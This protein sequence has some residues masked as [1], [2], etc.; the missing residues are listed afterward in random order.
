M[1]FTRFIMLLLMLWCIVSFHPTTVQAQSPDS[2]TVAST[3]EIRGRVL[4]ADSQDPVDRAE[5]SL[6]GT[7]LH[8]TTNR[9]GRFVLAGVTPGTHSLR[10]TRVGYEDILH[11]GITV[12]A[13]LSPEQEF[14]MRRRYSQLKAVTVT[15]GAY[16]FM[17]TNTATRQTM[18]REDIESVPQIGEDVFRAVNRLPGL[19]SGDYN[20]HFSIRGG[21]HD[22]T[23]ILLDGLELYEPYHLKDFNEGAISIVDAETIE[24]VQLMTGGFAAQYGNKRSG[25]FDITSRV[26]ETDKTR[27]SVGVSF[28]NARAMA[29]GPLWG[30]K[31]SWLVSA[32]SGF[33]DVVF[34]L[35]QQDDLPSPR[36]HDVF[37]K[38]QVR[39][40]PSH[41][42]S[43]DVLY[44]GDSW[45]FDARS[46]TGFADSLKT[47][48][49][50]NNRY[51]NSYVWSTLQSTLGS[52]TSVRSMVSASLV[53]RTRDGSE[54]YDPSRLPLYALSNERDY[55][56]L[57]FKQDWTHGVADAYILGFGVDVR[58]LKNTDR[59]NSIVFRDPD[60][61]TADPTGIY[62]VTTITNIDG[63]GTRL[64]LYLS[65][66]IRVRDPLIV[67]FGG[68]YDRASYTGDR[69]FS[70]RASAALRL[71]EGTTMRLGWGLYRQMQG[72]DEV[73]ALNND[74]RYFPSEKSEQWAG[75]LEQRFQSGA[76]LRVEAYTK[77]G[78]DLRPVYR[79]WKNGID[80]F[81][82]INEDRILVFP[83]EMTARGIELQYDHKLGERLRARAG[84]SFSI[85]EEVVDSLVSVNTA[86][87]VAFDTKHP[88]P[89]DQRHAVNVD[90]TYRLRQRWSLNGSL[91]FHTGWPATH[92]S[93]VDVV[94]EDGEPDTSVRPNKIYG[95]RL[96]SY[97]RFDVRATRRW[98]TK[99]GDMRF[100]A[101]IVN[102]T[103]HGNV[104]GYDYFRTYDTATPPNIVLEKDEETWFTILPSLGI[105]WSSSF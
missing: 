6:L 16:S 68:R 102:L 38:M 14:S 56:I 32:R 96:P 69:D 12:A 91:A 39:L 89:Q 85:A 57:G 97:Y 74:N 53:T 98:T 92:E 11:E 80:T 71:R 36:Y 90:F 41:R 46:T 42:L 5:V 35:I 8:A 31:G 10:A 18:S 100:F 51:G 66:R 93:L 65:N 103:N 21:R 48:E 25:V 61:P 1:K 60:D 29:R 3:T 99:R 49:D 7:D 63:T 45:K 26:P 59:F 64:G 82:E 27:Y 75:G 94:D 33:M 88:G 9:D 23:L 101:E 40:N 22:E 70:P 44:A 37:A 77:E 30:G 86:W 34:K 78:R 20:A 67:E 104:F 28:M 83:R 81:P 95:E 87:P 2:S 76:L 73:A 47:T 4:D 79:N 19:S 54:R 17:K 15:P 72:I 62:P 13:G 24:G 52:K 84:Y 55:S 50:A 58:Q 105:A 43:L